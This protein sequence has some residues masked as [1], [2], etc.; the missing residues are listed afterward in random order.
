MNATS[1]PRTRLLLGA[2][3]RPRVLRYYEVP[4]RSLP[5]RAVL[6]NGLAGEANPGASLNVAATAAAAVVYPRNSRRL[7]MA[8]SFLI[9]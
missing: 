9:G 3:T 6:H 8:V 1:I 2:G 4:H 5:G 7:I